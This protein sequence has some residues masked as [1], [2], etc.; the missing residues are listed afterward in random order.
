MKKF[1]F[2]A[3]IGKETFRPKGFYY[4]GK[5]HIIL[6]GDADK[7]HTIRRKERIQDVI[8]EISVNT[9]DSLYNT[10]DVNQI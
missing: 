2:K 7:D 6:V 10:K 9:G 5:N 4:Q 1:E 3:T 8:M